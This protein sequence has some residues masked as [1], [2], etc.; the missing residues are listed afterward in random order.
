MDTRT[1]CF[2]CG[3]DLPRKNGVY[4]SQKCYHDGKEKRLPLR[5]NGYT[6][7]SDGCWLWIGRKDSRGYGVFSGAVGQSRSAHRWAWILKNGRIPIGMDVCHHCDTP[8]CV[9]PDH[10][11]LGTVAANMTDAAMK[12]RIRFAQH[13][14]KLTPAQH[15]TIRRLYRKGVVGEPERFAKAFGVHKN[16]IQRIVHGYPSQ[17]WDKPSNPKVPFVLVPHVQKPVVGEV[18]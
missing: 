14:N 7:K 2:T 8:P 10:L 4:C 9:R 15:D 6:Q 17:R 16:T 5:F 3:K 11:F 1:T 18:W 12:G 13:L